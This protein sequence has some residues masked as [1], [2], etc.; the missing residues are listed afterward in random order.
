MSIEIRQAQLADYREII[1]LWQRAGLSYE[2]QGRDSPEAIA[3]QI[4]A[5]GRLIWVAQGRSGSL[6]GVVFGSH[7]GRK[8]W[9]N[10]LAVDPAHRREGIAQQLVQAAEAALK[11]EDISIVAALVEEP[12]PASMALF[13][14][15]GY[16][17]RRDIIY[18]RK[19]FKG[20]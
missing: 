6:L 7:D 9:I 3:H 15:L 4:E 11:Q 8:G 14:R 12:N 5:N 18:F 19:P 16:S 1:A 20:E 13:K 10:R 17:E 2:P